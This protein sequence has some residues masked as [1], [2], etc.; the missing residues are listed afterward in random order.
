MQEARCMHLI[1]WTLQSGSEHVGEFNGTYSIS[2]SVSVICILYML[3][4]L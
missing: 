3:A 2:V 1:P 4:M